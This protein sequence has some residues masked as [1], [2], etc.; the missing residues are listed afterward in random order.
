SRRRL[1]ESG[2]DGEVVG[3]QIGE[4]DLDAL[5]GALADQSLA[6]L[7]H[8]AGAVGV[9]GETVDRDAAQ[10]LRI[11]LDLIEAGDPAAEQRNESRKQA[12]SELVERDRALQR[13]A[14]RRDVG[15]HPALL[16]H[17]RGALREDL[18]RAGERT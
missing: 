5:P 2:R 10:P 4:R 7:E 17:L 15:L 8:G 18:D 14:E 12:L 11:R 3:R 13:G 6:G 9:L 16:L 1:A